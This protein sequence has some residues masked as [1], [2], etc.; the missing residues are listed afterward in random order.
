MM[1][2]KYILSYGVAFNEKNEMKQLSSYAQKGWLLE[3][4]VL[5]GMFYKLRKAEP[6]DIQYS[7]DYQAN[8]DEDYFKMFSEAG[9]NIV[10]SNH[11]FIHIFSAPTGTVPIYINEKSEVEKYLKMKNMTKTGVIYSLITALISYFLLV[12]SDNYFSKFKIVFRVLFVISIYIGTVFLATFSSYNNRCKRK[13][14]SEF[15][16]NRIFMKALFWLLFIAVL[17]VSYKNSIVGSILLFLLFA[18]QSIC[19]NKDRKE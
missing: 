11:N 6:K 5:G 1:N 14:S 8:A 13:S 10:S 12:L 9:W 7:L 4:T 3:K 19:S 18:M 16:E 2:T 17:I 15:G